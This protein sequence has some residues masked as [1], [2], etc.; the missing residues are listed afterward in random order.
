MLLAFLALLLVP[1]AASAQDRSGPPPE[2]NAAAWTLIDA[3]TGET[4]TSHEANVRR[5]IASTTKLMTAY[6]ALQRLGM[7]REVAAAPYYPIPG[8]SLLGLTPGDSVTVRDMI[9]GLILASGNDAAESLAV[10]VSGSEPAFVREMNRAAVRL[11]LAD[12]HYGNPIGLDEPGNYSTAADLAAFTRLLMKRRFLR[13]VF[14]TETITLPTLDPPDTIETRNTLLL[15]DPTATGVKTG[16]TLGAG[17]VLVG[18]ARRDGVELISAVLGAPSEADRDAETAELLVWG[19]RLYS[20]RR[21]FRRG[22]A[23]AHPDIAYTDDELSLL[24]KRGVEVGARD[25]QHLE[26]RVRAPEEV[27][28]PIRKGERIGSALVLLDGRHVA[29][30]PLLAGRR[31]AEAST[32]DKATSGPWLLIIGTVAASAILLLGLVIARRPRPS[33]VPVKEEQHLSRHQRRLMR[34]RRRRQRGGFGP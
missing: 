29:S 1:A 28:G 7:H 34:E 4:L 16:H 10:A 8:E 26:V 21:A 27:E 31:V 33:A 18:S 13:M 15:A 5:P 3:R 14:D 17:Y 24:A 19:F 23:V 32:L 30:V 2:L 25:D 22:E 11:G 20:P 12:T 6:L 9:Y